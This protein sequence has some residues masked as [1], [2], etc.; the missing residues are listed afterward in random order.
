MH[1][2][3]SEHSNLFVYLFFFVEKVLRTFF[4]YLFKS[5]SAPIHPLHSIAT[6]SPVDSDRIHLFDVKYY[7]LAR[8]SL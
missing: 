5:G 8:K 7:N 2:L 1:K 6:Q 4:P 3:F